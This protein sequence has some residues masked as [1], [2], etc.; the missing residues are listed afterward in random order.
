M[1]PGRRP[2]A[3]VL[4]AALAAAGACGVAAEDHAVRH[5][6]DDVPF[7]LLGEDPPTTTTTSP[8]RSESVT[9]FYVSGS[10]LVAAE[11][12]LSESAPL[13]TVLA[14]MAA[15]PTANEAVV[16]VRSALP[17]PDVVRQV[18]VAGGTATVDL[19][20]NF[21]DIPPGDQVLALAQIVYTLTARPGIGRVAFTLGGELIDVPRGDGS[22]PRESMAR[23]DYAGVAPA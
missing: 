20:P 3:G 11:R 12:P 2:A 9:V 13:F 16:G 21:Q 4:L 23:E 14:V 6:A 5:A 10:Q 22:L 18:G 15:G 17:G 1:R 7:N 19:T 8:A